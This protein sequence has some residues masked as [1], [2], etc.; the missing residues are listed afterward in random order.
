MDADKVDEG[1]L[2]EIAS[3]VAH[4]GVI[5]YP[6]DTLYGLAA[7]PWNPTAVRRIFAVKARDTAQALPLIAADTAQLETVLGPMPPL[8]ARLAGEFWPGPLTLLVPVPS[9][10]PLAV[11]S[12][13][14]TVAVRVPAHQLAAGLARAVG[15]PLTSTSANRSGEAATA[16]PDV[17]A[18]T[19]G[20]L[21]DGILD[22][23]RLPGGRPS[24][25]IDA[26]GAV[27]RLV[28][29]GAVPYERVVQFLAS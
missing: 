12:G 16:D 15:V 10:S 2:R 7:D 19:L 9:T 22:A 26:S 17:V 8:A 13:Q 25:I 11:A 21:I 27:P 1:L 18:K 24:T 28:R 14:A 5:A 6:T 20:D 3:L 4:G 29:A 23:G